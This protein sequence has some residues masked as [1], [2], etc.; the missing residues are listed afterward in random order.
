MAR[1]N[2]LPRRAFG[3][4]A[5]FISRPRGTFVPEFSHVAG[6]GTHLCTSEKQNASGQNAPLED[7]VMHPHI[8]TSRLA[9]ATASAICLFSSLQALHAGQARGAKVLE[10]YTLP[11]F[12]L[13]EFGLTAEELATGQANGLTATDLPAIASGLQRLA[14]KHFVGVTDRGP[15]FTRTTPTPGRVFP[16]PTY[17][18]TLVFFSAH[19]GRLT[20]HT[21][22]PIVVDDAG[23]PATGIPNAALDDSV[24]F[25][26]PT[27]T[28]QL[29]FNP[30]GLDLEDL[31]TL[32][33]GGFIVVDEYSPSLAIISDA[34]KVLK[35]YT[36]QGKALAGSAYTVSDTLPAILAQRR[37]NRGFESIAVADD[38]RTAYTLTQS[39]LGPTGATAP[40]RNSR[41]L[42][43]L[44]LDISDPL[45]LQVTGQFLVRMSDAATYPA[46][47]RPQDL[48]VSSAAW[49]SENKLLLLER[50]DEIGIGGAKL[51]LVDLEGATD[52]T[53]LPIA[54][55][56]TP[57]NVNTDLAALHIN[58]ATST[59]V[60]A[61]GE[62]PEITDF[63]LEG[64]AIL[65][66]NTVAITN[67]NDFSLGVPAPVSS[68]LWVIRLSDSLDLEK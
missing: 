30:N 39:P 23:T 46:G 41:I 50:S 25:E 34:G 56:L 54:A 60:Y 35:R 7:N 1:Y 10:E 33:D 24:P 5:R 26:S 58:V 15:T 22:I 45:N 38:G 53:A 44:R 8:Q 6:D 65:N 11:P 47:N 27:S 14:G 12:S 3:Q 43:V 28:T 36:P 49:V 55:T 37:A 2:A 59:V 51:V 18:P 32:P 21:L 19:D 67:D 9:V 20:P 57:E 13:S 66:K 42:R 31:H 48:K 17:T 68:K 63:K 4:S 61:N 16:L 40:T 29:P 64:L 62:T 52:I